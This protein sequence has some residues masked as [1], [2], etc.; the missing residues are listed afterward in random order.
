MLHNRLMSLA[1]ACTEVQAIIGRAQSLFAEA[2][3][4]PAAAGAAA[5]QLSTAAGSTATAAQAT[6]ELSGELESAHRG[7][8]GRS[9]TE[10]ANAADAD[11]TLSARATA[12]AELTRVGAARL[13]ALAKESQATSRAVATVTTP[14]GQRAILAALKSQVDRASQV[15]DETQQRASELAG[16]VRMVD[17]PLDTPPTPAEPADPNHLPESTLDGIHGTGSKDMPII[18][19]PG[20][21]GPPSTG[22]VPGGTTYVEAVPGSGVWIP[23]DQISGKLWMPSY[24]GELAPHGYEELAPGIWWPRPPAVD[25]TMDRPSYRG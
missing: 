24:P 6:A 14:A 18:K 21:L 13:D 12:A 17:Y 7:F 15:V 25:P 3:E 23:S 10:L 8:A 9:T 22:M 5:G 2:P 16:Q 11:T 20:E 19:A 4:P 1:Q